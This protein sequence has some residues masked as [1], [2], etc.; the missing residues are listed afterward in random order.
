MKSILIFCLLF[1]IPFSAF[2][3]Q[4]DNPYKTRYG[5]IGHWTDSLRWEQITLVTSLGA[6]PNDQLDDHDAIQQGID[7]ISAQGGGI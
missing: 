5:G 7:Q 2:C 6:Q 3:Q 1:L 4:T